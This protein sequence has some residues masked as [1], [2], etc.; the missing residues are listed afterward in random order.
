MLEWSH[1]FLPSSSD[2]SRP[3]VLSDQQA[4]FVVSFYEV[5]AKGVYVYRRAALEAAKDWGKSP[6]G[7]VIALAKFARSSGERAAA[8]SLPHYGPRTTVTISSRGHSFTK[9]SLP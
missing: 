6:L 4:E 1:R 5:D 9:S 2:T 7:A 3:L 8:A